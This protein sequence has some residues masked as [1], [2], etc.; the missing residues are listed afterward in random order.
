MDEKIRV[1]LSKLKMYSKNNYEGTKLYLEL[2]LSSISKIEEKEEFEEIISLIEEIDVNIWKE[3][4]LFYDDGNK[5]TNLKIQTLLFWDKKVKELTYEDANNVENKRFKGAMAIC[6]YKGFI[7][8]FLRFLNLV[9]VGIKSGIAIYLTRALYA[10][11]NIEMPNIKGIILNSFP[12]PTSFL[13]EN[14]SFN[15]YNNIDELFI[16]YGNSIICQYY[17]NIKNIIDNDLTK[18]FYFHKNK[19]ECKN[20][21]DIF[22]DSSDDEELLMAKHYSKIIEYIEKMFLNSNE[23]YVDIYIIIFTL[24]KYRDYIKISSSLKDSFQEFL[25]NKIIQENISN[26]YNKKMVIENKYF[27]LLPKC[28]SFENKYMYNFVLIMICSF[29]ACSVSFKVKMLDRL[30][31][32]YTVKNDIKLRNTINVIENLDYNNGK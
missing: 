4:F 3:F 8:V 19:M 10:F 5:T 32:Y 21:N 18:D 31:K 24:Y 20:E 17:A 15:P 12:F 16:N 2:I 25:C 29:A 6:Y 1:Y 7:D 23:S 26:N 13:D 30:K 28:L 14:V 11:S 22:S 9:L 27:G